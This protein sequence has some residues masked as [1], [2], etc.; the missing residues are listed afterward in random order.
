MILSDYMKAIKIIILFFLLTITSFNT[1]CATSKISSFIYQ[2]QDIKHKKLLNTDFDIG[3][4]D[5][6]DADFSYPQMQEL[7]D[8]NKII[9]SYLSIGEAEDY[10]DYWINGDFDNNPPSFLDEENPDFKGNFK[11]K[12][13]DPKWQEIVF[14]RLNEIIDA[15]YNGVYLDII[16]AYFFFEEKG[17]TAARQEMEDFVAEIARRVREQVLNF[18]IIPQNAAELV[19][20]SAYFNVI[21]GLGK[22]DTFLFDNKRIRR[23]VVNEDLKHLKKIIEAGKFVLVTDYPTKKRKQCLFIKMAKENRLIP[24]ASNRDLDKI[25]FPNCKK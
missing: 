4:I 9:V 21:D 25:E 23:K 24:F 2:L 22:E 19:E 13:W 14:N 3:V 10:R 11:V 8:Q 1:N 15:G 18:L 17:R 20:D 16:D 12:F 7:K 6:D 5:I